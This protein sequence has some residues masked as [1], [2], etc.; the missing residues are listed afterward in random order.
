MNNPIRSTLGSKD[1]L[2]SWPGCALTRIPFPAVLHPVHAEPADATDGHRSDPVHVLGH[3]A[4]PRQGARVPGLLRGLLPGQPHHALPRPQVKS[5]AHF[6]VCLLRS[7]ILYLSLFSFRFLRVFI[8]LFETRG[9]SWNVG[10]LCRLLLD[11]RSSFLPTAPL[12]FVFN[13]ANHHLVFGDLLRRPLPFK[14]PILRSVRFDYS[15]FSCALRGVPNAGM[16]M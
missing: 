11:D 1:L 15:Y 7:E 8:Q 13:Q 14:R 12:P 5:E 4:H 2:T 10:Q 6:L 9:D 16:A 3:L